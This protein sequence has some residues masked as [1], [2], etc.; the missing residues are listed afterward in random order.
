MIRPL[1]DIDLAR[2]APQPDDMKRK[3]LEAMRAGRPP[4]SY[5]PVRTCFGDIFNIQPEMFGESPRTDWAKIQRE[6]VKCCRSED[7][8][9]QNKRVARGLYEFAS[10][11]RIMSRRQEFFPLAMSIG[12]KVTFWLPMVVAIEDQPHAVFVEPRRTRGLTAEGRRFAFSMMHERIRAAD[13]DFAGLKLAI[14][15]FGDPEGEKRSVRLFT[16]EGVDLYGLG[17]LETMVSSTYEMWRQVC[18]DRERDARSRG[19]GTGSLI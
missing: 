18:E 3:S 1:P 10:D 9:E 19:T 4:F 15:R 6:L 14:V 13:E 12:R 11:R 8:L 2:I 5:K 17:D 16:D 7:E